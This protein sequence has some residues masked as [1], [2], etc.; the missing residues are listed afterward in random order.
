M[1]TLL[2]GKLHC[3]KITSQRQVLSPVSMTRIDL[4]NMA[5]TNYAYETAISQQ[6]CEIEHLAS[7]VCLIKFL[8]DLYIQS[9]LLLST[10]FKPFN[11]LLK[12]RQVL[13]CN[14]GYQ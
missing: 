3:N 6:E 8:T 12:K 4:G 14:P 5:A 11:K 1:A 9:Y 7:R 13:K 2:S 10:F